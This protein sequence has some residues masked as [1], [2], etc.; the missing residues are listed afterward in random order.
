MTAKLL[1]EDKAHA[2]IRFLKP[3][4]DKVISDLGT[5]RSIV[6]SCKASRGDL[7]ADFNAG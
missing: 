5:G 6:L 7:E 4:E 1:V 2:A 3:L